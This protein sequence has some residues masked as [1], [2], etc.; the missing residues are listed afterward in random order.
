[1]PIIFRHGIYRPNFIQII[2]E[3][4]I[5]INPDSM[6]ASP[7]EGIKYGSIVITNMPKPNPMVR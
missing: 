2:S 3:V 6:V 7:Y 5:A 1:M 4:T